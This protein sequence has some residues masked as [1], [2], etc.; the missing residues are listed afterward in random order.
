[1][2]EH[3]AG[4]VEHSQDDL[5][6]QSH[7]VEKAEHFARYRR[8]AW[9]AGLGGLAARG[10]ALSLI[11]ASMPLD[12]APGASPQGNPLVMG[13]AGLLYLASA[14]G[15]IAC[16]SLYAL[17]R[18]RSGLWGLVVLPCSFL[19]SLLVLLLIEDFGYGPARRRLE[20]FGTVDIPLARPGGAAIGGILVVTLVFFGIGAARIG[21][22]FNANLHRF[23]EQAKQGRAHLPGATAEA[24]PEQDVDAGPLPDIAKRPCRVGSTPGGAAILLDGEPTGKTTPAE[25]TIWAGKDHTVRVALEGFAPAEKG[26]FAGLKD[27]PE[28]SFDLVAYP[29]VEV[30]S[31]PDGAEVLVGGKLK[32]SATPGWFYGEAAPETTLTVRKRGFVDVTQKIAVEK[33]QPASV[34][35][36]LVPAFYLVV[37]SKPEGAQVILDGIKTGLKTPVELAVAAGKRHELQ[38]EHGGATTP[39]SKLKPL[40]A[41]ASTKLFIDIA[42]AQQAELKARIKKLTAEL[43]RW[44][45][46]LRKLEAKETGFAESAAVER[47]R[48][49]QMDQA[50]QKVDELNSELDTAREDLLGL[51]PPS[52]PGD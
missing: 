8:G 11:L 43:A 2:N 49:A 28:L 5:D 45:S 24:A 40:K 21:K 39:K 51:Q 18:D 32:L 7:L 19:I 17:S 26:V 29:K 34:S 37:E 22:V 41:G 6:L 33:G 12:L 20:Q 14:V 35:V 4:V 13:L 30:A 15:F 27:E 36:R 23:Q 47:R 44:N 31:E 9:W 25:I 46:I 16:V 48:Q 1:L 3:L 50:Q 52:K 42:A 38:L 10:V